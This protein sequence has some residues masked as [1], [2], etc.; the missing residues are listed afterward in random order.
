MRAAGRRIALAGIDASS[1]AGSHHLANAG[2]IVLVAGRYFFAAGDN[3]AKGAD[4]I[5]DQRMPPLARWK[6]DHPPIGPLQSW[7]KMVL[8]CFNPYQNTR[9]SRY[10]AAC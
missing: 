4:E 10:H 6:D 2:V 1:T 5:V 7:L 9:L 8:A 3:K